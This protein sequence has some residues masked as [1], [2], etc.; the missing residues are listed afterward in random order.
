MSLTALEA[1]AIATTNRCRNIPTN[2][3]AVEPVLG[4]RLRLRVASSLGGP[5]FP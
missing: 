2:H 5:R 3:P 1:A 4:H